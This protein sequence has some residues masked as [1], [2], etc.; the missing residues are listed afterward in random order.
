MFRLFEVETLTLLIYFV[1]TF[2]D[3]TEVIW[4]NLLD[5]SALTS[6]GV[7]DPMVVA[8][9]AFPAISVSDSWRSHWY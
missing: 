8:A 9:M 1:A 5:L 7:I 2:H 6:I 4:S 3:H